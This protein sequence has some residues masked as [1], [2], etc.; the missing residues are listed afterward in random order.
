MKK[1]ILIILGLSVSGILSAKK[2]KFSVDMDTITPNV[3]GIHITGDFQVAAGFASDWDPGI[4]PLSQ[5]INNPNI[6]SIVVDIP[7]FQ[8]YEFKFVNGIFGYETE[9]VPIE[10]RVNYNFIDNRWIYVDSTAND[11]TIVQ[12]VIYGANAPV[13]KYLYRFYVDMSNVVAV[14]PKG[15]HVAGDFNNWDTLSARMYSFDGLVYEYITYV[16]TTLKTTQQEY[17]FLNGNTTADYETVPGACAT[18]GNNRGTFVTMDVMLSTVCFAYCSACVT[19]V[20]DND[21]TNDIIIYPNPMNNQST[22]TL[23]KEATVVWIRDIFGKTI[24]KYFSSSKTIHIQRGNMSSGVYF[25]TV[26]GITKKLIVR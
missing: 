22:L 11:T 16:D 2:I 1:V 23:S 9:F 5:D 6:Y 21:I 24:D 15:V 25:V 19:A 12:P 18:G 10:S 7:A 17:K 26:N 13:G 20:A 3:N 14:S 8:K 4:T